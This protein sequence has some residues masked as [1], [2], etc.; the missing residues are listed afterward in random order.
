[1]V[2]HN[3]PSGDLEPSH[4][5]LDIAARLGGLG[6]GFHIVDN[7]VES[8]YRVVEAFRP[9][10]TESL[11][12]V[13]IEE[14]LGNNG[15]IAAL[16]PGYEERPD[17][18][19][20]AQA[21]GE[22]FNRD[23]VAVIEAGTGTGKSLAYLVPA[24][25]WSRQNRE[26]VIVATRTINLQEQLMRKDLPLLKQAT[27]I[28]FYAVLVKGRGN[29]L[30]RRRLE[31]AFAETGLFDEQQTFELKSLLGWSEKTA[32]GDR[33][34]LTVTPEESLWEEVRCE[35]INAP[36]RTVHTIQTA[37]FIKRG[38][39]PLRPICSWSTTPSFWPISLCGAAPITTVRRRCSRRV[40]G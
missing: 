25:L 37:S 33:E 32:N 21:V 17:Q 9:T 13:Q 36:G 3:H 5:D 23:R 14:I 26:R 30:C 22:A 35:G 16:L 18:L 40:N 38:V 31:T 15:S 7:S 11:K 4:A 2:I 28:E 24:I 19:R 8:V 1:M 6:V 34:E 20:M 29:Y 12:P 27:G 10:E 39:R